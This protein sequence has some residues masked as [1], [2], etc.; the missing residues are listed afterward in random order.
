MA[1]FLGLADQR[2][3]LARD[4]RVLPTTIPVLDDDL[5]LRHILAGRIRMRLHVAAKVD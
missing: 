3:K 4:L 2:D 5:H 1:S